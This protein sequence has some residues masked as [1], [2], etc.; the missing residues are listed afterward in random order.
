MDS[1]L[2]P[3]YKI[4]EAHRF[5]PGLEAI[6]TFVGS[7]RLAT[8]PPLKRDRNIV[9]EQHIRNL[10]ENEIVEFNSRVVDGCLSAV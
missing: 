7:L 10:S 2:G 3:I 1:F 6:P 8:Q 5:P 9:K 4:V